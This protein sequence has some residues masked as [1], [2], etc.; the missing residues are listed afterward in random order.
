MTSAEDVA[1]NSDVDSQRGSIE[2][3]SP[4]LDADDVT[5]P[6]PEVVA[7]VELTGQTLEPTASVTHDGES[8]RDDRP[9]L[10]A[11]SPTLAAM[12]EDS[13]HHADD[14][15]PT[16]AASPPPLP[17]PPLDTNVAAADNDEAALVITDVAK[18]VS[19]VN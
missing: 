9:M 1:E 14:W 6:S 3:Q 7:V 13:R 2:H 10:D 15:W 16:I 19:L 17:S 4:Q 8:S 12:S 5:D 18:Y 11:S